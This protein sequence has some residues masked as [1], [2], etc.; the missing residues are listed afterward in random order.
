VHIF[1]NAPQDS[2]TVNALL[3]DLLRRIKS[4]CLQKRYAILHSDNAGCYHGAQTIA[5]VPEI[6]RGGGLVIKRWDFSDPQSGKGPCD[7][8][9]AV[10]KRK[11]RLFV[12]E[13]NKCTNGE[14]FLHEHLRTAGLKLQP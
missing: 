9:A 10:V 12:D 8:V 1:D 6:S 11:V 2:L 13:N 4:E 14:E 3:V 5:S 7:R